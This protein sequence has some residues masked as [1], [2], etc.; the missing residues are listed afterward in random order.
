[1]ALGRFL[2]SFSLLSF[3]LLHDHGAFYR[4]AISVYRNHLQVVGGVGGQARDSLHVGLG[5]VSYFHHAVA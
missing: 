2:S 4:A 1:M 5:V 3:G